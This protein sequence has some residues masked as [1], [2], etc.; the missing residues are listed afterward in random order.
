MHSSTYYSACSCFY[1]TEFICNSVLRVIFCFLDLWIFKTSSIGKIIYIV[2]LIFPLLPFYNHSKIRRQ[3][4]KKND[5]VE[6]GNKEKKNIGRKQWVIVIL[7][8]SLAEMGQQKTWKFWQLG[9]II[10]K[11]GE[12]QIVTFWMWQHGNKSIS[13]SEVLEVVFSINCSRM[14]FINLLSHH[15]R[16]W[17]IYSEQERG[18]PG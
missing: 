8:Q 7:L 3:K 16:N 10:T 2:Y 14:F 15:C 5:G 12:K 13:N 1:I 17:I 11:I 18:V 4:K 9:D 6:K